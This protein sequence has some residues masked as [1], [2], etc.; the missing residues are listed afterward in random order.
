[1]EWNRFIR[2]VLQLA[3]G[4]DGTRRVRPGFVC[5]GGGSMHCSEPLAARPREA[6]GARNWGSRN[7][8]TRDSGVASGFVS[9]DRKKKRIKSRDRS[10]LRRRLLAG[11][12]RG[13]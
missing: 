4:A 7:R 2:V 8:H 10:R 11:F 1:M 13:G 9:T 5:S 6:I 3:R 12:S